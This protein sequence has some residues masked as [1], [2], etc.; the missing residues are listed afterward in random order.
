MK[1]PRR[2]PTRGMRV[3]DRRRH[4]LSRVKFEPRLSIDLGTVTAARTGLLLCAT[5]HN[6]PPAFQPRAR[7]ET[8]APPSGV[9]HT[10][11]Q[12]TQHMCNIMCLL[13]RGRSVIK[14]EDKKRRGPG[15]GEE[16]RPRGLFAPPKFPGG[17]CMY[18]RMPF[19]VVVVAAVVVT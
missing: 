10:C 12:A 6:I 13:G 3:R 1:T 4:G 9:A 11:S 5:H 14:R 17:H 2:N 8:R 16:T 15:L 7:A 18:R 19:Y